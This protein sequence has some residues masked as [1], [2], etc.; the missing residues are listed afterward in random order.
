MVDRGW[1]GNG[2]ASPAGGAYPSAL[3]EAKK[4]IKRMAKRW[5]R[6]GG[7]LAHGQRLVWL[8]VEIA[9][10]VS[11]WRDRD[12]E[13][14]L[15][16]L[17]T[18]LT[19]KEPVGLLGEWISHHQA[20]GIDRVFLYG[21]E[22]MAK[23]VADKFAGR[24]V[25]AGH[26]KDNAN[27]V[28]RDYR[29]HHAEARSWGIF[30]DRDAYLWAGDGYTLPQ[31]VTAA[32][33]RGFTKIVLHHKRFQRREGAQ[34]PSESIYAIGACA[35]TATDGAHSPRAIAKARFVIRSDGRNSAVAGRAL[36]MDRNILRLNHYTGEQAA[37][38]NRDLSLR[39]VPHRNASAALPD[40]L[41]ETMAL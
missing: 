26:A 40:A 35:T 28:Y 7:R 8:P 10:T 15:L 39:D 38:N 16:D 11:L 12:H 27:A 29:D 3:R 33:R 5:L 23:T 24:V 20:C 34:N 36:I 41:L 6:A 2:A 17:V 32:N 37:M 21:D 13:A 22:E 19:P 4:S 18:V 30:L 25:M 31:V 14:P 9:K 1:I